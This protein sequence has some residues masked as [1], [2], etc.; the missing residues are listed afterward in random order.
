MGTNY[1]IKRKDDVSYEIH[2]GKASAGWKFLFN[3]HREYGLLTLSDIKG[4]LNHDENLYIEN[5]YGVICS[6]DDLLSVIKRHSEGGLTAG[7]DLMTGWVDKY[8]KISYGRLMNKNF[9]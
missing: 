8:G 4:L 9:C 6:Y 1:Y 3:G 7:A 5:E 2:I